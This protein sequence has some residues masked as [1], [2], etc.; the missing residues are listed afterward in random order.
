MLLYLIYDLFAIFLKDGVAIFKLYFRTLAVECSTFQFHFH[1]HPDT[2]KSDSQPR[3][4]QFD[5]LFQQ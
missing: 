5:I 3:K 1:L 4:I 2:I